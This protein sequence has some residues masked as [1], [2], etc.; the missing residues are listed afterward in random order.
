[1][2]KR[3][4]WTFITLILMVIIFLFSSENGEESSK[5]SGFIVDL[6]KF[7]SSWPN[8]EH[9]IRKCAHFTIYAALGVSSYLMIGTYSLTRKQS[10]KWA[11]LLCFLYACSDEFHQSFI[12]NRS[13]QFSDVLLDTCGASLTILVSYL[14]TKSRQT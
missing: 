14:W 13:A 10:L 6:L 7:L 11:I 5:T 3:V 1:M 2:K 12:P 8:L 9:F 4:F